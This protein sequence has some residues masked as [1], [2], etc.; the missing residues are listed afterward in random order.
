MK[1]ANK[2]IFI[3]EDDSAIADVYKTV[4]EK[5]HFRVEVFGL[6]QEVIKAVK[7]LSTNKE[8]KPDI[9]LL[10]LILPDING[11][12]VLKE[13]RGSEDLRDIMQFFKQESKVLPKEIKEEFFFAKQAA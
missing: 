10:D 8:K 11:M 12:E 1:E 9:V 3:V 6:G 7:E 13:I 2:K 5:S 4:I